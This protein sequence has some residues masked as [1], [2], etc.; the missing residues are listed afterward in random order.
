[1]LQKVTE[2]NARITAQELQS[3][4]DRHGMKLPMPYQ[5]FILAVNGGGYPVP[6]AFPIAGLADNPLGVLQALFGI[7]A[8]RETE[9]LDR[10]LEELQDS[11]PK[12]VLPIG[13]TEGYDLVVLDLRRAD[14]PVL[15]WDRRSFWGS[16]VWDENDLYLVAEN[17]RS[18][19][20][21]LHESPY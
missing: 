9:D 10:V 1:M 4:S 19:L 6:S 12:G 16:N 14:A 15:F 21:V 7:N 18:F 13:C 8:A 5:E 3:F 17:F 20:D 2:P 11:T